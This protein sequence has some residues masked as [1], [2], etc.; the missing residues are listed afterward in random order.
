MD[1]KERARRYSNIKILL[2][3]AETLLLILYLAAFQF[4]KLSNLLKGTVQSFT[5]HPYA[6][7]TFYFI[8][9]AGV[10]YVLAFPL[11]YFGSYELEHRFELSN[12]G[13]AAWVKDEAK[14]AALSL[15]ISLILINVLYIFLR[16]FQTMWW[17]W[18]AVFWVFFT[19]VLSRV[20]PTL[21]I[22]LFY[23]YK[24][25][26]DNELRRRI[27]ALAGAAGV[28]VVDTYQIDF[29]RKTRKANA[30]VVGLGRTRRIILADNLLRDFT[31]SEI[32]TVI[33]HELGHHKMRHMAKLLSLGGIVSAFTFYAAHL[34]L[35]ASLERLGAEAVYDIGIFPLL[36]V[37]L[38]AFSFLLMPVQNGFSRALERAADGF[39]LRLTGDKES[40]ISLMRRLAEKNLSNTQPHRLVE[41]IFFNHP[42]ISRR[43]KF[44]REFTK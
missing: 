37:I 19:V 12:Q 15:T 20:L 11:K 14:D 44:A 42:S 10:Y 43:V 18:M 25:L 27:M 5:A 40:F 24:P 13:L 36:A 33:G 34:A 32:E 16:N 7:V 31:M 17:V 22:P 39:T 26:Q 9:L 21:I 28:K 3:L 4:L 29:S 1:P 2:T 35:T 41:F 6:E 8:I 38:V 23:K 30:A